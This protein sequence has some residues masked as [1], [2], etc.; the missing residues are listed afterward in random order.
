MIG[1]QLK[2]FFFNIFYSKTILDD[3][4]MFASS[5]LTFLKNM[6]FHFILANKSSNRVC[7]LLL[8]MLINKFTLSCF[9]FIFSKNILRNKFVKVGIIFLISSQKIYNYLWSMF[10]F[11]L[12]NLYFSKWISNSPNFF[13]FDH[14]NKIYEILFLCLKKILFLNFFHQN[15][16]MEKYYSFFEFSLFRMKIRVNTGMK[17]YLINRDILRLS[18]LNII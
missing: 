17:Y 15:K 16:D 8:C 14:Y 10:L 9:N 18:G 1:N 12:P 13:L 3:K 6:Y 11:S 2:F 4:L 7:F 5:R